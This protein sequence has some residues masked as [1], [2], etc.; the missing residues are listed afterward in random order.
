MVNAYPTFAGAIGAVADE[1]ARRT[2]PNLRAE[3]VAYGR[4]RWSR[5]RPGCRARTT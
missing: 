5:A 2:L 3:V 4:Y 1:F